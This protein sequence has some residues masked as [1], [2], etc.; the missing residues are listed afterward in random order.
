MFDHRNILQFFSDLFHIFQSKLR[1][2]SLASPEADAHFNFFAFSKP[3]ASILHFETSVVLRGF[4]PEPDLFNLYF[5]LCPARFTLFFGLFVNE[6]AVIDDARYWRFCI[7][8]NFHKV[9]F[10]FSG[11]L[12]SLFDFDDAAV[13]TSGV[14]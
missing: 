4:G 11:D 9:K 10:S 2:I 5:F 14:D 7:G 8:S 3:A 13:F 12:Q 6:F 1:I